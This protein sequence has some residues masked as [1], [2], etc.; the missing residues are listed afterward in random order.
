[1]AFTCPECGTRQRGGQPGS[2][3]ACTS[4][5]NPIVVPH[6]EPAAAPPV[7]APTPRAPATDLDPR[8]RLW[9]TA[10]LV[11]VIVAAAHAGLFLLLT[12]EARSARR[13]LESRHGESALRAATRPSDAPQP[14]TPAYATWRLDVERFDA[15]EDWRRHGKHVALLRT[16]F[17]ASFL[18]QVG[19]TLWILF[20]LLGRQRSR[21][22]P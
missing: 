6:E 14:G 7:E 22:A 13:M 2:I 8:A 12:H 4:C 9:G 20:R 15:S 11:L 18:V 16:G 1:L 10:S 21:K 5:R 17:L 3:V 19:I